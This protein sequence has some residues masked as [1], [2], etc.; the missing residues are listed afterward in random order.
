MVPAV[1]IVGAVLLTLMASCGAVITSGAPPA[2]F[3]KQGQLSFF[4]QGA[5][6]KIAQ[7]D[8]E[9]ADTPPQRTRGLMYMRYLPPDAGMLFIFD[10][11]RPVTFWM[12]NTF[13][14]LDIIFVNGAR[15]II[16]AA[17]NATPLSEALIP[18]HGN[19][20]YVVEVNA[21][22]CE[23]HGLQEGDTVDFRRITATEPVRK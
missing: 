15:A 11:A 23:A 1:A 3:V 21:G 6:E 14:P 10:S 7:I 5:G 20:R 19:A 22:Y 13:I 16:S 12:R 17:K 2:H 18:S 8:I 9:L 4:R